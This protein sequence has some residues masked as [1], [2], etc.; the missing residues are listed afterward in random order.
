MKEWLSLDSPTWLV[1]TYDPLEW[2]EAM[3]VKVFDAWLPR[4][5]TERVW[6]WKVM[7]IDS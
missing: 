1:E 7:Q 2:A 6:E 3:A 4:V 5:R